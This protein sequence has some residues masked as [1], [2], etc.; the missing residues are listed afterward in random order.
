MESRAC[1]YNGANGNGN[2]GRRFDALQ[3][4]KNARKH[5]NRT[6]TR[7]QAQTPLKTLYTSSA[8]QFTPRPTPT[9]TKTGIVLHNNT[10][11]CK[12]HK[13]AK[14]SIKTSEKS[15]TCSSFGRTISLPAA[16]AGRCGRVGRLIADSAGS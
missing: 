2:G 13:N 14:L 6:N 8:V 11:V 12:P 10:A 15:L 5:A 1:I 3:R 7:Q 4:G 9:P 16:R